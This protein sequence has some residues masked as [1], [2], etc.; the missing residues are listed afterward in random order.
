[1]INVMHSSVEFSRVMEGDYD[2]DW[3]PNLVQT[4]QSTML[5][6]IPQNDPQNG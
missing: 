4:I 3:H 2:L 1:M 6:E 5:G